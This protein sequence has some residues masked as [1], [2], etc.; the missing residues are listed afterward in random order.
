MSGFV[1][2]A[3]WFVMVSDAVDKM[4]WCVREI[5]FKV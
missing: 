3:W 2:G 1:V 4:L 5:V